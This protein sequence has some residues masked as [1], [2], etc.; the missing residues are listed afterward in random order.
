MVEHGWTDNYSDS[1]QCNN[2]PPYTPVLRQCRRHCCHSRRPSLPKPAQSNEVRDTQ[3][4][5]EDMSRMCLYE[6]CR[7][8]S[9]LTRPYCPH[10]RACSVED[11]DES[12]WV[13]VASTHWPTTMRTVTAA[14]PPTNTEMLKD[15]VMLGKMLRQP[16]KKQNHSKRLTTRFNPEACFQAPPAKYLF[17]LMR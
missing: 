2:I 15:S 6:S 11:F 10:P 7:Y 12:G 1:H 3:N 13:R 4:D 5:H 9:V 14:K 16:W 8:S 17:S